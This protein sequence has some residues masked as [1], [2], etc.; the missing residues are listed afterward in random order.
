M[1]FLTFSVS[2]LALFILSWH[3]LQTCPTQDT[4]LDWPSSK[5]VPVPLHPVSGLSL[6]WGLHKVA[7][8][9]GL[10]MPTRL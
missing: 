1:P 4:C 9:L 5:V 7:S 10:R 8:A 2:L 6:D 3:S